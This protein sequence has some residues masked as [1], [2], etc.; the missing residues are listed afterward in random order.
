MGILT[1][2]VNN[3][4]TTE[5]NHKEPLKLITFMLYYAYYIHLKTR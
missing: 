4:D 3:G 5:T 2:T 1:I